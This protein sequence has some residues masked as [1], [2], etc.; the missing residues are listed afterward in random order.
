MKHIPTRHS[1]FLPWGSWQFSWTHKPQADQEDTIQSVEQGI[2]QSWEAE[3]AGPKHNVFSTGLETAWTE[4]KKWPESH[5]LNIPRMFPIFIWVVALFTSA[6][7]LNRLYANK[8]STL[9]LYV[10]LSST[11]LAFGVRKGKKRQWQRACIWV[12]C[13]TE[14]SLG[15]QERTGN[16]DKSYLELWS[17]KN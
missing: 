15:I 17:L 8:L 11:L 4:K 13:L 16:L 12:S 6:L 14:Y 2:L 1:P 9:F 7:W 3:G 10:L 5:S